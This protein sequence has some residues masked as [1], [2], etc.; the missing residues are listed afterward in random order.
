[1]GIACSSLEYVYVEGLIELLC[2]KNLFR[3]WGCGDPLPNLTVIALLPHSPSIDYFHSVFLKLKNSHVY[4]QNW[5]R[6]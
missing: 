4:Y 3:T 6:E 2:M 5:T 1:M